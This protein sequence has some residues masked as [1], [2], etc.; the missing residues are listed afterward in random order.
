MGVPVNKTLVRRAVFLATD[1]LPCVLIYIYNIYAYYI[2]VYIYVCIYLCV[3]IY[4]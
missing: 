2:Y 3:Y 1:T 4:I